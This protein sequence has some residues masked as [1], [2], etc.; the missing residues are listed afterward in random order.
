MKVERY[1]DSNDEA[2]VNVKFTDRYRA[3]VILP[4]SEF[5]RC[6]GNVD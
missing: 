6:Y 4:E 3:E 5:I 2:W 1:T